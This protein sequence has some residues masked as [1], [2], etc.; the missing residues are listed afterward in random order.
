MVDKSKDNRLDSEIEKRLADLFGEEDMSFGEESPI[1]EKDT[2]AE[3]NKSE[4][5][6]APVEDEDIFDLTEAVT[7]ESVGEGATDDYPLAELKNLVLSIDW[8]ITEEALTDFLAQVDSL[9]STYK[10]EKIILTFLQL[11]GS[12]GVYIQTNRGNAHPK[13]FKILNSVFSRLEEVVR[14]ANMTVAEKKKLLR[15]EMNKYKQLRNQ[16]SKKKAAKV[17]RKEIISAPR[18]LESLIKAP[19]QKEAARSGRKVTEK[20]ASK[21]REPVSDALQSIA[22][23][24][25]AVEELKKFIHSELNALKQELRI[26][27][28]S[29]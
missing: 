29:K 8:E 4:E 16:V 24:A 10:N 6:Q 9:K 3:E 22:N 2:V 17:S 14:S 23:L 28:K 27:H 21:S 26:L 15:T 12:L 11:L 13:T 19:R 1:E 7:E 5:E 20:A 18:E 25:E